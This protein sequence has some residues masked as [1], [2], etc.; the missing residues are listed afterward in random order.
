MGSHSPQVF[1]SSLLWLNGWMLT[2][3]LASVCSV[4]A[5][6]RISV[7]KF[8]CFVDLTCGKTELCWKRR[9]RLNQLINSMFSRRARMDCVK[10]FGMYV[11]MYVRNMEYLCS[12]RQ[13]YSLDCHG[14]PMRNECIIVLWTWRISEHDGPLSHRQHFCRMCTDISRVLVVC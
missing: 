10:N 4:L 9:Y 7:L 2:V 11:C 3:F 13:P 6:S 1:G 14:D 12:R 5:F 8:E